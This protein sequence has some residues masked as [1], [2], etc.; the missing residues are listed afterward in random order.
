MP[1]GPLYLEALVETPGLVMAQATGTVAYTGSAANGAPVPV[2]LTASALNATGLSFPV[3]VG[4]VTGAVKITGAQSGL[5]EGWVLASQ[6]ID[7]ELTILQLA[8]V[9]F[10][11]GSSTENYE[12]FG[13]L[14][15]TYQLTFLPDFSMTGV[16]NND[17]D[18]ATYS[19]MGVSGSP[20]SVT[21]VGGGPVVSDFTYAFQ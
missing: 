14:D 2:Q 7:G 13:L 21:I 17:L 18:N 4:R 10:A 3:G 19:T 6:L 1:V 12:V 5:G 9:T 20:A 11:P 8:E 16:L 15:G